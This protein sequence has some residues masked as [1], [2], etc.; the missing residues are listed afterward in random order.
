MPIS[1]S[2]Y[3]NRV[4]LGCCEDGEMNP[5]KL[6][7]LTWLQDDTFLAVS[8]GKLV[9]QSI[10]HHLNVAPSSAGATVEEE[11]ILDLGYCKTIPWDTGLM[12]LS[13]DSRAR[14]GV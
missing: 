12:Q 6:R 7:L 8:Q 3:A 13:S 14:R 4:D 9:S 2:P 5:L 10:L 11:G 1:F